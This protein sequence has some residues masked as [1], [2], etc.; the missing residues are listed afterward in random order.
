MKIEFVPFK[1]WHIYTIDER[2]ETKE[3]WIVR[4]NAKILEEHP[5]M[6][7]TVDGV[8]KACGGCVYLWPNTGEFWAVTSSDIKKYSK[9][10]NQFVINLIDD[11]TRALNLTRLQATVIEDFKIGHR[12]VEYLGFHLEAKMPKYVEDKTYWLY[13]KIVEV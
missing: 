4:R 10:F 13:S 1:A 12:W 5:A 3:V 9:V 2:S 8:I 7:M 11:V 6:T